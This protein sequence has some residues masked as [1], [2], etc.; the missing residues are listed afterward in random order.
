MQRS[1]GTRRFRV[2]DMVPCLTRIIIIAVMLAGLVFLPVSGAPVTAGISTE[3]SGDSRLSATAYEYQGMALMAQRN[4]NAVISTT[5]EGLSL[6]PDNAGLWCLKGY[7]LRKTGHYAE[8]V[9]NVTR[10][11]TLDPGP[12]RYA[13]R[14]FA[15]LALG[16]NDE[17]LDDANTAIAMNASYTSAYGVRA[18]ALFNKGNL[19][20][21][22]QVIGTGIAL[23]PENP[24]F[25]QLKGKIMAAQGNCTGAAGA[26]RRSLEINPGYDLPWPQFTNATTDLRDAET[27]CAAVPVA[28]PVPTQASLPAV[29]AGAALV[30]AVLTRER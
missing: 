1:A 16:R 10:G 6:Y 8:A 28:K 11:I 3:S 4:W 26:F 30:L 24:F 19:T 9:D 23:D 12:V 25:W 14:G 18:L 29:L 20:G 22:G 5:G 2:H 7:A 27:Q 21:A 13:N 15:L 17:A